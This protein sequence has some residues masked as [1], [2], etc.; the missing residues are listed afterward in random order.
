M[1]KVDVVI[2]QRGRFVAWN[3]SQ[4]AYVGDSSAEKAFPS[5]LFKPVVV[6]A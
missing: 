4:I 3:Q 2:A 6:P 5:I 1:E